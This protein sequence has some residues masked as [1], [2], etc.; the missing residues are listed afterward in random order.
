MTW[1]GEP[2]AEDVTL[3]LVLAELLEIEEVDIVTL[4]IGPST[5]L[6]YGV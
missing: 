1:S 6:A 4:D 5:D 2:L 3:A